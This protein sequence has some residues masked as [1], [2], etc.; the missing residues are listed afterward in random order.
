[1]DYVQEDGD[2]NN[3]LSDILDTS[4]AVFRVPG[5]NEPR[6]GVDRLFRPNQLANVLTFR[7]SNKATFR[8]EFHKYDDFKHVLWLQNCTQVKK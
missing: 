1:M 5:D 2:V 8:G 3:V 7:Q 6:V 4:R